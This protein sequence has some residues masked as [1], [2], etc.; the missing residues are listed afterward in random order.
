[1][2]R[3]FCPKCYDESGE[4]E[5]HFYKRARIHDVLV[6]RFGSCEGRPEALDPSAGS[7]VGLMEAVYERLVRNIR[8]NH[9][10]KP[11][12]LVRI[13][14]AC[15]MVLQSQLIGFEF[16]VAHQLQYQE[17]SEVPT[18][19]VSHRPAKKGYMPPNMHLRI[20]SGEVPGSHV[21]SLVR[22]CGNQ[23]GLGFGKLDQS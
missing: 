13:V 6:S 10:E 3:L 17:R 1:M 19:G 8:K 2:Q 11:A 23:F 15:S 5:F 9:L 18:H 14:T 4:A 16:F 7:G 12:K 22:K 21:P 20:E